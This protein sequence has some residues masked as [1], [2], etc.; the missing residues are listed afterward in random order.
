MTV[1]ISLL[2]GINVAGQKIIKMADLRALFKALAFNHVQSYIQSGNVIFNTA[3]V[4]ESDCKLL[5]N[6]I[7][8]AILDHYNFDVPVFVLATKTLK[9]ARESLPFNNIDLAVDGSKVLLVFLSD[10][11]KNSIELLTPYLKNN[12]HLRIIGKVLYLH[13]EDGFGR[14]KLTLSNIE[15]KL[16]VKATGRNLKTVDKL[17]ALAELNMQPEP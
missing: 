16:Q 9:S 11:P 3:S 10:V 1:Y 5:G 13:C 15:K 6:K 7:N 12:E 17:I 4:D 14:S 2:R 8:Q